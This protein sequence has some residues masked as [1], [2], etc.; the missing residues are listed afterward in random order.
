MEAFQKNNI[1][2]GNLEKARKII[3]NGIEVQDKYLIDQL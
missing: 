1:G 2:N 3:A